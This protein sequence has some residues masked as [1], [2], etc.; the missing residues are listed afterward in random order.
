MTSASPVLRGGPDGP[1]GMKLLHATAIMFAAALLALFATL[2]ASF[3]QQTLDPDVRDALGRINTPQFSNADQALLFANNDAINAARLNNEISDAYYQAAQGD[4]DRISQNIAAAAAE[5]AGA[6][7][8]VQIRTSPEY[9]PGTDSDYITEVRSRAQIEQMQESYNR[10]VNDFLKEGLEDRA[11]PRSSTWHNKLDVDFMA[12]P[13]YIRDPAEF[14]R[15]AE[16]NNDAYKSRFA[17]QYEKI[18]RQKGGGKIGPQHVNGYM[19]EMERFAS[20]KRGK[21]EELL[22]KPPSYFNDPANRAELYRTMAQEQ[23]YVSRLESLDDYLRAQ[24]GLPPRNRGVTSSKLGSNRSPGNAANT[25]AGSALAEAARADALEDLADTMAQVSRNNPGFDRHAA[26]S[27][28]SVIEKLPPN[29]RAAALA[30]VQASGRPGLVDQ[31]IDASRR[32]G[33]MPPGSSL[34][35]DA[36]RAGSKLDDANDLAR[37]LDALR[38][39][40]GG[41]RAI[42]PAIGVLDS[43]GQAANAAEMVAVTSQLAGLL[44]E[45]DQALDPA[46]PPDVAQQLLEDIRLRAGELRDSAILG[47]IMER[48][49]VVAGIYGGLFVGCLTGELISPSVAA[50]ELG[51]GAAATGSCLDRHVAA[52]DRFSDW[53]TGEDQAREQNREQLCEKFRQAVN[54]GRA[55]MKDDWSVL[56]ACQFIRYGNPIDHMFDRVDPNAPL[57]EAAETGEEELAPDAPAEAVRAQIETLFAAVEAT[58]ASAEATRQELAGTC[59]PLMEAPVLA[60]SGQAP[61]VDMGSI[62]KDLD[63]AMSA[64]RQAR[65]RI[66]QGGETPEVLLSAVSRF[67]ARAREESD[68]ACRLSGIAATPLDGIRE[69]A[70]NARNHAVLAAQVGQGSIERIQASQAGL[71]GELP[72]PGEFAVRATPPQGDDRAVCGL[73]AGIP[74]DR[75]MVDTIPAAVEKATRQLAAAFKLIRH[76]NQP[77]A[78]DNTLR[79]AGLQQRVKVLVAPGIDFEACAARF[80]EISA[81]CTGIS[82]AQG[83]DLKA[84][85]DA[86]AAV[87]RAVRDGEAAASRRHAAAVAALKEEIQQAGE[88]GD[89]ARQCF[90]NAE[91]GVPGPEALLDQLADLS[92]LGCTR[93][94]IQDRISAIRD[95]ELE[96]DPRGGSLVAGLERIRAGIETASDAL[97]SINRQISNAKKSEEIRGVSQLVTN[98]RRALDGVPREID[99][100]WLRESLEEAARW[101]S[102]REAELDRKNETYEEAE[103]RCMRK[104]G[105]RFSSVGGE[106][107]SYTCRYCNEGRLPSNGKCYKPETLANQ[108]CNENNPGTGYEAY[109]F[110]SNGKYSCRLTPEAAERWCN[111][112]NKGAG[113]TAHL[114]DDG[115]YDCRKD[116]R[117]AQREAIQYCR[118]VAR[119]NGKVYAATQFNRDGTYRCRWCEP[120]FYYAKGRCHARQQQVRQPAPRQQQAIRCI[121]P[122]PCHVDMSM[123]AAG[124]ARE[125][126]CKAEYAQLVRQYNECKARGGR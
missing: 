65:S 105:V 30:R 69:A 31:I 63:A 13:E 64:A 125:R 53:L 91:N 112:N 85:L 50:G 54:Q 55:R 88:A 100:G 115:R 92:G 41:R 33:R 4:Y 111:D 19:S 77:D 95:A 74:G 98:A 109:D 121:Y 51:E 114:R 80:L 117:T 28:A 47:A 87:H 8:D 20:K 35:D 12:D 11:P 94:A 32:G 21:I 46:T 67:A 34:L 108:W 22:K 103:Q 56:E 15:I 23:K 6:K 73:V 106:A 39:A 124:E 42:G 59:G 104:Y 40:G 72:D 82:G 58:I 60:S 99:C 96:S 68:K 61:G 81:Q 110:K 120:G 116:P 101:S 126:Q 119:D 107:G 45:L 123:T 71:E 83:R 37:K 7:F 14:R 75:F 26:D 9:S 57:A 84:R 76:E 86:Y 78:V 43:I 66:D 89:R 38:D 29:R 5:E 79:Y 62:H 27:I 49:P 44:A 90:E 52:M 118:G 48:F 1:G 113:W 3:A 16:V 18:S 93:G 17:A 70:L 10:R 36:A 122:P 102:Q 24:E 25:R 97:Q 2:S